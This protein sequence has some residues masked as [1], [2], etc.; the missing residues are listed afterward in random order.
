[1]PEGGSG[2]TLKVVV[3][4]FHS[5]FIEL[6]HPVRYQTVLGTWTLIYD[7]GFPF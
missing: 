1:M 7:F 6:L 3:S 4:F 5:I 2:G